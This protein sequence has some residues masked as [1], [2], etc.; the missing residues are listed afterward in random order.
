MGEYADMLHSFASTLSQPEAV[1]G[2]LRELFE[3][4][5]LSYRDLEK[6]SGVSKSQIWDVIHGKKMP[7]VVTWACIAKALTEGMTQER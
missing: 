3:H 5:S 7:S 1:S 4:S 6:S 2:V